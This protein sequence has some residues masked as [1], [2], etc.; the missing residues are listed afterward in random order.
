MSFKCIGTYSKL[1]KG[2][3]DICIIMPKNKKSPTINCI[4]DIVN[5]FFDDDGI[6]TVSNK[7]PYVVILFLRFIAPDDYKIIICTLK[8]DLPDD[9]SYLDSNGNI[10]EK[11][12]NLPNI[13]RKKHILKTPGKPDKSFTTSLN[14]Y[15]KKKRQV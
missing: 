4:S 15:R 8:D 2:I 10:R 3:G 12:D 1:Y 5:M 6:C 11:I 9:G 13:F 14:H 7:L